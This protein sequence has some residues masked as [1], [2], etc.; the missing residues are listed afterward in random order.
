VSEQETGARE[1]APASDRGLADF[2]HISG[3]LAFGTIDDLEL[4]RLA[5]FQRPEA[6]ALDRREVNED[7]SAAVTFDETI[8]FGVVEP[9]D[10]AC[11]T[12]LSFPALQWRGAWRRMTPTPGAAWGG[13]RGHKKRPRVRGLDLR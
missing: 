2:G 4:D 1:G 11:D 13:H 6:I 7:V 8:A 12:H 9:L 10:L 3:L 5:L